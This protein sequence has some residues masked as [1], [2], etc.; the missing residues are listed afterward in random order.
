MLIQEK[1][2]LSQ[3]DMHSGNEFMKRLLYI[4]TILVCSTPQ[5]MGQEKT[6]YFCNVEDSVLEYVRITSEG[7]VKWYHTMR[8][9][10]VKQ[11]GGSI[12]VDYT[13]HILNHKHKPYYGDEPAQLHAAIDD[14]TVILDV[15]ESVAAVFRTLLPSGA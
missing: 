7:D 11:V 5:M 12:A 14:G 1:F 10:D 3:Y 6:P 9:E 8:I 13:S 15:A 2:L 4:L